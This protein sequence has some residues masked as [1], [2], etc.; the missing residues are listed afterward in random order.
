M[1]PTRTLVL[2]AAASVACLIAWQS[3][4]VV[5]ART[6]LAIEELQK[7]AASQ[8]ND[9]AIHNDLANLLELAGRID[10]AEATYR[11]ALSIDPAFQTAR[12]NLAMLLQETG[13][14]REAKKEL[15]RV[16][17]AE[18]ERAWAHYQL[19][20]IAERAGRSRRAIASYARAFQLEP[21]LTFPRNNPQIVDNKL[22]VQALLA[23]FGTA[24]PAATAPRDYADPA[25]VGRAVADAIRSGLEPEPGSAADSPRAAVVR[26]PIAASSIV[27]GGDSPDRG[28]TE[29]VPSRV[30]DAS[31]LQP[32]ARTGQVVPGD[33]GGAVR[34]RR[35]R[36]AAGG[37]VYEG[38][39]RGAGRTAPPSSTRGGGFRP[40][41]LSTGS[42]DTDLVRRPAVEMAPA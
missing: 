23:A 21:A 20:V 26:N 31:D 28:E 15:D 3:D 32:G 10:E 37:T 16:I 27:A 38:P 2:C 5:P 19:G 13:R 18:P 39:T 30:L 25:G 17:E 36:S 1:T 6:G 7:K 29:K 11:T 35:D 40:G 12:L 9:A 41:R 14:A 22:M 4:A 42:L 8:P 34:S 24:S 33:G